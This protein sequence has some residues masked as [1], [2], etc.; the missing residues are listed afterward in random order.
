MDTGEELRR[1]ESDLGVAQACV[2]QQGRRHPA[3]VNAVLHPVGI[4]LPSE[5]IYHGIDGFG[6]M[7]LDLKLKLHR[8]RSP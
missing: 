8:L 2:L 4:W 1:G 7:V 3:R 5:H 6:L